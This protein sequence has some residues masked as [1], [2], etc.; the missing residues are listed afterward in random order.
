MST[1]AFRLPVVTSSRSFG[2]FS[3]SA[4]GTGMRVQVATPDGYAPEPAGGA[5]LTHDPAEAVKDADAVFTDVWAS[6]GQEKEAAER[7]DK[8]A[9]FMVDHA[10]MSQAK[11]DALFLHCLPAHRDEEVAASVVDGPQSV[12]WPEAENRL[13]AIRGLFLFLLDQAGG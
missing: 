12:V 13:H 6:M 3:N 5:V 8:F 10:L 9:G 1:E 11:P 2:S 4:R 7:R